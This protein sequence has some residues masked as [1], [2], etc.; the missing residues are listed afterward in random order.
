[1]RIGLAILVRLGSKRLAEKHL[2]KCGQFTF[3]EILTKRVLL[4]NPYVS[5]KEVYLCTGRDAVNDPLI[6]VSQLLGISIF[7]GDDNH[8]PNRLLEL[9]IDEKLE[10]IVAIDGD[11]VLMSPEAVIAACESLLRGSVYSSTSGWPFGMNVSAYN[12]LFLKKESARWRDET[13]DTGW[14]K[15]FDVQAAEVVKSPINFSPFDAHR[16]TLDY[17]ED[18]QFFQAVYS[19]AGDSMLQFDTARIVDL[20][21]QHQLYLINAN[22][23]ERY[24]ENFTSEMN[25]QENENLRSRLHAVIPG[26]SHTYSRGDDQFSSFVPALF[27]RGEGCHLF[28]KAGDRWIDF[29]MGLRSVN[30]GY[31][32]SEICDA[33]YQEAMKGNNLT[34][35]SYTELIAAERLVDLVP[36]VD[37]VKFAKHGSTV[38]TAACKLARAYT[39]RKRIAVPEEQPFFS[40][41]DWFIGTTPMNRGVLD[42]SAMFTHKFQYGNLASLKQLLDE[43]PGEFAAVMMEPATHLSPCVCDGPAFSDCSQ[44]EARKGNFLHKAKELVHAHGALFILDEMITGFR[45]HLKGAQYFYGIEPDLCTFGKAMANGFAVAALAGKREFMSLGDILKPN[46]ERV[47]LTSTTHGAEMGS[48]GAFLKTIE[49]LERDHV[50][51]SNWRMGGLLQQGLKNLAKEFGLEKHFEVSGY[52]CSPLYV[53][54][55][56]AGAVSLPFRSLFLQETARRR[57][58][59]PYI[60]P[61]FAHTREVIEKTLEIVREVMPV[62]CRAVN[63]GVSELLTDAVVKPVFRKFN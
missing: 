58:I 14:G 8:I 52:A 20:V 30:I 28:D 16:Y 27:E 32:N 26:G 48:L 41:D 60:S 50:V 56:A 62:M 61:S 12:T 17:P 33:F 47:F 2:M 18:V 35:A 36:S 15:V 45:W 54:R 38:T 44:C 10:G 24:W 21:E 34:R 22:V 37:M 9:A 63:D 7:R 6:R 43:F 5:P 49:I 57:L 1:M 53:W 4:L 19:V 25:K 11:D 42:E 3:L 23:N 59:I 55:D 13:L 31:A 51:E 46:A 40:F 29:G 39:G